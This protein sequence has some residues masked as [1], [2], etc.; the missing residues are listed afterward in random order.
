MKDF[1]RFVEMV[2]LSGRETIDEVLLNAS[3]KDIKAYA[4]SST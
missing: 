1:R 2:R 3:K 4:K